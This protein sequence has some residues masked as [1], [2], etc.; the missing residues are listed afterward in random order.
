MMVHYWWLL[1]HSGPCEA[2]SSPRV[3]MFMFPQ[4]YQSQKEKK[5]S[6]FK[7]N[8]RKKERVRKRFKAD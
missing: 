2:G 6:L 8:K 7:K 4:F 3:F 5:Y 1:V